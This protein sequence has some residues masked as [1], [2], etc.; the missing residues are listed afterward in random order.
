MRSRL[1]GSVSHMTVNSRVIGW[2]TP[3]GKL[4]NSMKQDQPLFVLE[5]GPTVGWKTFNDDSGAPD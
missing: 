3:R 5:D 1:F 4:S 2:F